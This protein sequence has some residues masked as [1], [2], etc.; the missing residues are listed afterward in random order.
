MQMN[1]KEFFK[2]AIE[3]SRI[4][5]EMSEASKLLLNTFQKYSRSLQ[6]N[7]SLLK[8]PKNLAKIA[9]TFFVLIFWKKKL[10]VSAVFIL[11]CYLNTT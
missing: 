3:P 10:I 1:D 7:F 6:S 8:A 11:K 5:L 9:R 2:N 4:I